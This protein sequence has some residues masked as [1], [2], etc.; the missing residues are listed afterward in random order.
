MKVKINIG[1]LTRIGKKHMPG[2]P[3]E[4]CDAILCAAIDRQQWDVVRQMQSL[5]ASAARRLTNA[6]YSA[7]LD[8]VEAIQSAENAAYGSYWPRHYDGR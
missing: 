6:G 4:I 5:G 2:R 3:L 7:Y 8:M 1:V